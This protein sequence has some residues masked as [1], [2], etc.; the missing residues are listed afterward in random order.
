MLPPGFPAVIRDGVDALNWAATV[1]DR[2]LLRVPEWVAELKPET[3]RAIAEARERAKRSGVLH[4]FAFQDANSWTQKFT[5][6]RRDF[7][8]LGKRLKHRTR[9]EWGS[10][11]AANYFTGLD[12]TRLQ[13]PNKRL[14]LWLGESEEQIQRRR[15]EFDSLAHWLDKYLRTHAQ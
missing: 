14:L 13:C 2:A 10:G 11:T 12:V 9:D 3:D 1:V 4:V 7:D 5:D 15:I 6:L 8:E